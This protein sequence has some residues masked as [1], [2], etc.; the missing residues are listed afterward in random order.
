[1]A[2]ILMRCRTVLANMALENEGHKAIFN[3]WPISHEPLRSDAKNLV[4]LIDEALA[5]Y[6]QEFHLLDAAQEVQH[7]SDCA[8][9][10]APALPVGP[11]DCGARRSR[12]VDPASV[13]ELFKDGYLTVAEAIDALEN[14]FD[15]AAPQPASNAYPPLDREQISKIIYDAFPFEPRHG[16]AHKPAWVF[17]GNSLMQDRARCAADAIL[18]LSSTGGGPAT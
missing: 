4:P 12:Q 6:H 17:D 1:M 5:A 8:V 13:L 3:R 7:D 16:Q 9:H 18:A 15:P 14:V 10:N 11:C 2:G